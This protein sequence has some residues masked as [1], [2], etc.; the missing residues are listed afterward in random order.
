MEAGTKFR[1]FKDFS[2][3][4]PKVA[5]AKNASSATQVMP[6][7]GKAISYQFQFSCP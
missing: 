2:E 1:T 6:Q 4:G 3:I 7:R 5:K